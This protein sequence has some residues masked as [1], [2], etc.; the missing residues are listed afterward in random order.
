LHQILSQYT[1]CHAA[2][3]LILHLQ[4]KG[5]KDAQSTVEQEIADNLYYIVKTLKDAAGCDP[6]LVMDNIKNQA[7]PDD[8]IN[9]RYGV[10]ILPACC[11]QCGHKGG[12]AWSR[13]NTVSRCPKRRPIITTHH[14]LLLLLLLCRSASWRSVVSFR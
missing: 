3:A 1:Y 14:V 9:S 4:T 8:G 10:H 2:A 5:K 13:V 11:A 7:I 12:H 6:I